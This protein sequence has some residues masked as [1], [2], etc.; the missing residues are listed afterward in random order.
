MKPTV[1]NIALTNLDR[2][3]E[4]LGFKKNNGILSVP[5]TIS[6]ISFT[7]RNI[8]DEFEVSNRPAER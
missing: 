5:E 6:E 4:L 3:Y 1:C 7:E 8:L 2:S